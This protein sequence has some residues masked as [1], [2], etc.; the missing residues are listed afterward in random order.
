MIVYGFIEDTNSI[1][2][3]HEIWC[4][5]WWLGFRINWL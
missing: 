4:G 5:S 1:F 3:V 2:F